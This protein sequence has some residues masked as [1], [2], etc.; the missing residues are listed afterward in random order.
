MTNKI[1]ERR[2][3]ESITD[4]TFKHGKF[5]CI[6]EWA[7]GHF[8]YSRLDEHNNVIDENCGYI[9]L[10]CSRGFLFMMKIALA[11]HK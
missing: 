1:I 9:Q 5:I 11:T 10:K 4:L 3:M 7:D 8:A 2:Y 6:G